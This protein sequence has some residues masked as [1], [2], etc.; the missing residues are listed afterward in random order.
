M[1]PLVIPLT[2]LVIALVLFGAARGVI[3]V[4]E[5]Q[6]QRRT[7]SFLAIKTRDLDVGSFE[8]H[9]RENY[10]LYG[11]ELIDLKEEIHSVL[12]EHP[13]GR[14]FHYNT[15]EKA[16]KNLGGRKG[17]AIVDDGRIVWE[18]ALAKS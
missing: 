7:D 13:E 4:L 10:S 9:F 12:K 11:S 1:K 15:P 5:G 8:D 16:W 17:Y 2:C 6:Q 18:Q 3:H 14:L